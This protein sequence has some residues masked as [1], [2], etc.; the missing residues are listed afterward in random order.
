[1]NSLIS[2]NAVLP[3]LLAGNSVILKPSPQ[4]PLVA[5]R[6]VEFYTKAGL[7]QGLLQTIHLGTLE[8]LESLCAR[9]EVAHIAFTGSV[10]GG[11]AV[12]KAAVNSE[13]PF[14]STYP[15]FPFIPR[16]EYLLSYGG[17]C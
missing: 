11:M 14:K 7:P 17:R 1:M 9:P 4:T 5:E 8:E 10:M 15:Y 16:I 3:A 6:F 13:N 2:I 12:Q